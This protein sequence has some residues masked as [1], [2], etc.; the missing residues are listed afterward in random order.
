MI[1]LSPRYFVLPIIA[2][3]VIGSLPAPADSGATSGVATNGGS[4]CGPAISS[5]KDP[6]LRAAFERFDRTQSAAATKV[7]ALYRNS[8]A[9]A[10]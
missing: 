10:N 2:L 8:M 1:K 5:I 9:H 4:G 6:G 7:C 3:V